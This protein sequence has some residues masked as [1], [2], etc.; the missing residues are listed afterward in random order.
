MSSLKYD[1]EIDLSNTNNSHTLMVEL[2]GGNKTVLDIGCATGYLARA[3]VGRGCVVSGLERDPEAAAEAAPDLDKL[4]V[5]D[6]ESDDLAELFGPAS[7]DVVVFGD[8]L[9]HLRDPLAALRSAR[10]VLAPRGYVVASIPNI[11]HGSVRLAL[12]QGRFDYRPIGL[13]DETHLRFFTRKSM[14]RLFHLA[15]M[16]PVDV[17]RTTAGLFETHV[18]VDQGTVPPELVEQLLADPEALTY[19]FVLKA[20]VDDADAAV[21]ELHAREQAQRDQ[22]AELQRD[23]A[24]GEGERLAASARAAELETLV[25]DLER[26]QRELAGELADTRAELER[27]LGSATMRHTE[28]LRRVYSRL[29]RLAGR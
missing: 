13:L 10:A 28:P 15:G 16:A 8:V 14:E 17:R 22:V 1:T 19:Q 29:R 3:L 25:G 5:G 26:R 2:V 7:Y 4:V 6:V 24:R 23:V 20:V 27:V 9:E 21:W 12:L 18:V 11:A